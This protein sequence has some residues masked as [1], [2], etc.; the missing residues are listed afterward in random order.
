[1]GAE[2]L[3]SS[4]N[5]RPRRCWTRVALVLGVFPQILV[6]TGVGAVPITFIASG[7]VVDS[8]VE[9]LGAPVALGTPIRWTYTFESSTDD[10]DSAL[11][12]HGDYLRQPFQS[13]FE[14]GSLALDLPSSIRFFIAVWLDDQLNPGFFGSSSYRVGTQGFVDAEVIATGQRISFADISLE[15][16]DSSATSITSDELP[17]TPPNLDDFDTQRFRVFVPTAA[18]NTSFVA[19]VDSLVLLPEPGTGSLLLLGFALLAAQR[20]R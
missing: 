6:A 14:I 10:F 20:R 4:R 5:V 19:S 17:L 8:D 11:D 15:L 16:F 2:N 3:G 7:S 9:L 12:I 18:G 13:T 1:M